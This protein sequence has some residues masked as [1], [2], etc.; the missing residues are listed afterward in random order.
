[1]KVET[2]SIIAALL[3][4][5]CSSASVRVKNPDDATAQ[6]NR[7]VEQGD[8]V[9]L[10][11][12]L[13]PARYDRVALD[14]FVEYC[15]QLDEDKRSD[16]LGLSSDE[17][18]AVQADIE[19]SRGAHRSVTLRLTEKGWRISE[20]DRGANLVS[21]PMR[22]FQQLQELASSEVLA[23]AIAVMEPQAQSQ[24]TEELGL[25]RQ[26]LSSN[27]LANIEIYGD[28]AVV[29]FEIVTINLSRWENGRWYFS[30]MSPGSA[31]DYY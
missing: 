11:Q 17:T 13:H 29:R 21:D 9:E 10:G 5:G 23:Q 19:D 1:M 3:L 16:M 7:A 14:T 4:A 2:T 28:Q 12:M 24:Y 27:Q 22:V 30:S 26:A 20:F 31:T 25:L 6:W 15:E 18:D 8:C